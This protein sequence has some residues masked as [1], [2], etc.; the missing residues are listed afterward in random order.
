MSLEAVDGQQVRLVYKDDLS[1]TNGWQAVTP[2]FPDG[3]TNVVG[4]TLSI[5]DPAST[6]VSRRFYRI[7]AKPQ[8]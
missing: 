5:M 3:W 8:Q 2:P 7:E 6:N 4:S 1:D